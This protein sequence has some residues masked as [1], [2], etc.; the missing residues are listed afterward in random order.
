MSPTAPAYEEEGVTSGSK[1][2][3]TLPDAKSYRAD[4][5]VIAKTSGDT[6]IVKR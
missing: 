5:L 3:L 6:T 2:I 4:A 1:D